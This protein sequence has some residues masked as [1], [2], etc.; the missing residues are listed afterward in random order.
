M[1]DKTQDFEN[2]SS[3]PFSNKEFKSVIANLKNKKAEGYDTISSEM[4]KNSP[5]WT[6][7]MITLIYVFINHL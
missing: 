6:C 3:Q 7:Y 2:I 4:V 5:E 1:V